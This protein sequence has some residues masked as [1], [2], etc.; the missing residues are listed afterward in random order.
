MVYIGSSRKT[1][2]ITQENPISKNKNKQQKFQEWHI[3]TFLVTL[4]FQ[5]TFAKNLNTCFIG[6]GIERK[7]VM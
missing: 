1:R 7:A 4:T 6:N 3:L 2:A 5:K